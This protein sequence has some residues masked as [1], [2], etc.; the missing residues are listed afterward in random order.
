[1][2]VVGGFN[3]KNALVVSCVFTHVKEEELHGIGPPC[4]S[5]Q[6]ASAESSSPAASRQPNCHFGYNAIPSK[7][8]KSG[9]IYV[10]IC[11]LH[12]PG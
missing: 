12:L 6:L 8:T 1:M 9:D 2:L 4:K 11:T 3:E 5:I 10:R 7:N